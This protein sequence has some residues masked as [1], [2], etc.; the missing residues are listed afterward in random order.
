[1]YR[2]LTIFPYGFP[3]FSLIVVVEDVVFDY[4]VSATFSSAPGVPDR[5][6]NPEIAQK[7]DQLLN[8]INLICDKS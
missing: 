4:Y 3:N 2:Y 7:T 6:A 8:D 1:M 5:R